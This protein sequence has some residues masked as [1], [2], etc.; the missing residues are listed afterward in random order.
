MLMTTHTA[1]SDEDLLYKE[2]EHI[3]RR[4][5]SMGVEFT[6]EENGIVVNSMFVRDEL[7]EALMGL[8]KVNEKLL[9]HA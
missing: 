3:M 6:R 8:V 5:H 2:R 9:G 1:I 7:L 4:L